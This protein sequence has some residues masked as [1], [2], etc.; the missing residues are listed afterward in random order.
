MFDVRTILVP[1][2]FSACSLAALEHAV[3]LA[4]P[5]RVTIHVLHVVDPIA[6]GLGEVGPIATGVLTRFQ[7]RLA[8]L[9]TSAATRDVKTEVHVA[10]GSVEDEIFDMVDRYQV[11]VIVMGTHGRSGWGHLLLG[12]TTERVVR[13]APCPVLTVKERRATSRV[14]DVTAVVGESAV[15]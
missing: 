10:V 14:D 9:T 2:D 7:D 5:R 11:D 4:A 13:R 6:S 15:R 3:A 1:V 12:G 8:R